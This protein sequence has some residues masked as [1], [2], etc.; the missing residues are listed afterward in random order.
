MADPSGS[1]D[2]SSLHID[3]LISIIRLLDAPS[4]LAYSGVCAAWR[5]A[6]ADFVGVPLTR[7]PWVMSWD[8]E[9]GF[10]E[11]EM[12][13]GPT[14]AT[15]RCLLGAR[16]ANSSNLVLYNPFAPPSAANFIPLPPISSFE[17]M[18]TVYNSDGDGRI[19]GYVHDESD[20]WGHESMGS[21]FYQ[22]AILSCAPSTASADGAAAYTAAVIHCDN[23]SL[24]FAKAGDTEWRQAWTIDE[25]ETVKFTRNYWEDGEYVT[26]HIR[27]DD[28][29]FDVAHHDGRFY[30]VTKNGTVE[31]WDLSGPSTEIVRETIGR[32]L[33]FAQDESAP[34]VNSLGRLA[35]SQGTRGSEFGEVPPGRKGPDW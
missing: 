5:A 34:G 23:R 30:T 19:V 2:W 28:E 6:A 7:T 17:C 3:L 9:L 27:L 11:D 21:S 32:K 16:N 31:S 18:L 14:S 25:E 13:L 29:N 15:L 20:T 26:E 33:G 10:D 1:P 8:S 4:A 35:A 24:S 22:K 12:E